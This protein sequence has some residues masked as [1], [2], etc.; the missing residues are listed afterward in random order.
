MSHTCSFQTKH[1]TIYWLTCHSLSQLTY[2]RPFY[3]PMPPS[4]G[5]L[6]IPEPTCISIHVV[7]VTPFPF[8]YP[9]GLPVGFSRIDSQFLWGFMFLLLSSLSNWNSFFPFIFQLTFSPVSL[10]N[11]MANKTDV[12][13][14]PFFFSPHPLIPSHRSM[15]LSWH[16]LAQRNSPLSESL[17]RKMT[18]LS[19]G[20][21]RHEWDTVPGLGRSNMEHL[22]HGVNMRG[23][24]A[25]WYS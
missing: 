8:T 20:F 24:Y 7:I 2:W 23:D 11:L 3:P 9:I 13:R 25:F 12:S 5:L 22:F 4:Y 17:F 21:Q 10:F 16:A 1:L 6:P 18:T 19:R 15:L 14:T